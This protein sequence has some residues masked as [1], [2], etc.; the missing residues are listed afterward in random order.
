M[1]DY[2]SLEPASSLTL[3]TYERVRADILNGHWSPG[4]KL[5]IEAL[6]EHYDSGATPVRE[7]LNR[8]AAEG[9]VQHLDQRGFIVTP[10]S[11]DALR[12]LATT[13]VWVET[14][15][16]TQSMQ[17]RSSAWE[18]RLVLALHR[19]ATTK[20]SLQLD[21]YVENP[22]W[23][24]LHRELHMALLSNCGSRWLMGFCEQLYDQA[25]RYRQLAVR[26]SYKR[27]QELDEH[28]AVVDAVLAGDAALA[29]QTLTAH[30]D[31]TAQIILNSG[32]TET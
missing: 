21:A 14:L 11:E 7:A 31:K 32:A 29:C 22:K 26:V 27:R 17:A 20:R 19:L 30:Y 23:E 16:L 6:R 12:E 8:L 15:A 9:W 13:R 10:V 25:Y 2:L 18:E 24:K 5:G 1:S 3:S 4:N 28:K